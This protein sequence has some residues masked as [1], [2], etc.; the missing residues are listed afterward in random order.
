MRVL[1][2]LAPTVQEDILKKALKDSGISWRGEERVR[3]IELGAGRRGIVL[4]G[5]TLEA[6]NCSKLAIAVPGTNNLQAAALY[7]PFIMILPLDWADEYPLDGVPG[8]LPLWLPGIRR[9]KRAYIS[10]FNDRT[11]CVSLPNR[12][13]GRMIAPEIR[14]IFQP[15][16]VSR[17]AVSLLESPE[18]LKEMSRAFWDLTHERGASVRMAERVTEWAR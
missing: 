11:S 10:R 17:L 2:P 13:A 4:R 7:I 9:L 12:L 1:F 5:R 15:E 18:R 16:M 6:L 14:G 3:E 8:I